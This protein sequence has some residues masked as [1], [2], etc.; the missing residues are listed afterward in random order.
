[1]E[2]QSE[3]GPGTV[4]KR[5]A[6]EILFQHLYQS[7]IDQKKLLE[8]FSMKAKWSDKLH[9]GFLCS[10]STC[11]AVEILRMLW[12]EENCIDE[13]HMTMHQFRGE[14]LSN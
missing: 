14:D 6:F 1:M 8:T 13:A 7:R 4:G 11:I 10:Y 3:Q 5:E 2:Y 12:T 9:C